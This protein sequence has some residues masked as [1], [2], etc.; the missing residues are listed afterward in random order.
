MKRKQSKDEVKETHGLELQSDEI[1]NS[2]LPAR[3]LLIDLENCPSQ[4][5]QLMENLAQYTHVVICYAQSGAKIP[6][7]WIVPL[8][9]TVNENRLK[10]V[11]M[12][13]GGKNSAD[14]GLS[15]WAGVLM[16]QL[17]PQAQFDIV[18]NDTDLDHVVDLLLSQGRKTERVGLQKYVVQDPVTTGKMVT[19]IDCRN[20]LQEYCLHLV[21]HC[22]SRPAK[23][24]TLINNI[25]S[26]FKSDLMDPEKLFNE[27]CQKRAIS[28]NGKKI[29]YSQQIIDKLAGV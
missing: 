16:A 12:P 15:F 24:E 2:S 11:K 28:L 19:D 29:N 17:P 10:I 25:K 27:L 8:T 5:H 13:N 14:F 22:K 6:L 26:K 3:V 21:N 18:S 23:Q 4:L 1:D 9:S 20:F 7:D